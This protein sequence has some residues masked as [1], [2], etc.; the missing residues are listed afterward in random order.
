MA[1][2]GAV[3]DDERTMEGDQEVETHGGTSTEV[4]IHSISHHWAVA[5]CIGM[6]TIGARAPRHDRQHVLKGKL[7]RW[8][9]S[10]KLIFY[11]Q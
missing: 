4:S 7:H 9:P 5:D 6:G 3:E 8:L 11:S 1:L 10:V 2:R